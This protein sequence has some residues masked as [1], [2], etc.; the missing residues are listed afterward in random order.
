MELCGISTINLLKNK[1]NQESPF[2][3]LGS[4][5]PGRREHGKSGSKQTAAARRGGAQGWRRQRSSP[6]GKPNLSLRDQS[7]LNLYCKNSPSEQAIL[8]GSSWR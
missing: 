3:L 7:L 2:H 8:F 6:C 5:P 4:P 1:V